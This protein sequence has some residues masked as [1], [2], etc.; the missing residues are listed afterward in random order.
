MSEQQ[1]NINHEAVHVPSCRNPFRDS[2][3]ED[4]FFSDLCEVVTQ[5]IT[6]ADFGLM[7]EEWDSGVY[8]ISK[9]IWIGR[10]TKD[11]EISLADSVWYS[12][13]RLWHQSL[14]TLSAYL[15]W[16]HVYKDFWPFAIRLVLSASLM[17]HEFC[18]GGDGSCDCECFTPEP[19]NSAKCLE[20]GHG[21]SGKHPDVEQAASQSNV[22]P[23][24]ATLSNVTLSNTA[25]S[26][27]APSNM[28]PSNTASLQVHGPSLNNISTWLT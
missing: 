22:A 9:T 14:L 15:Y 7:P 16:I 11:V 24:N 27:A 18:R 5:N 26:N 4:V 17:A 2:E 3:E 23:S 10:P 6:P 1:A 25:P 19:D 28:A 13:A 20:C 12:Q 8:P 21:I